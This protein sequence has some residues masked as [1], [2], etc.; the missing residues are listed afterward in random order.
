VNHL[1]ILF[2]MLKA[3]SRVLQIFLEVQQIRLLWVFSQRKQS[4]C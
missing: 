4:K 1:K 2:R 3:S